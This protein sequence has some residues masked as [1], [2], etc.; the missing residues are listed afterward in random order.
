MSKA[1]IEY[2]EFLDLWAKADEIIDSP[3]LVT[4]YEAMG[5]TLFEDMRSMRCSTPPYFRS[6]IYEFDWTQTIELFRKAREAR[7]SEDVETLRDLY[8][9]SLSLFKS[10]LE[11]TRMHQMIQKVLFHHNEFEKSKK[12]GL[13][14]LIRRSTRAD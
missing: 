12:D 4:T 13:E 3:E 9:Q 1:E 7:D 11:D 2:A 5:T 6:L 14:E 8:S 10:T